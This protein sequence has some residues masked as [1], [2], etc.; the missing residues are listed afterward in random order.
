MRERRSLYWRLNWYRQSEL[1]GALL[2]GRMV[3][4]ATDP[5]LV[6]RLTSHCA[7]EARHAWLWMRTLETLGLPS[8]RIRR[9]YQSFYLDEISKPRTLTEVLALTH[10]FEHRVH[11]HFTDELGRRG[12]PDLARRTFRAMLRDEQQHLDWIAGWLSAQPAAAAVLDR[13]RSADE[14]VV[15][16]LTPYRERLWDIEGLGEERI[17]G[18]DGIHRDA[19]QELHT[20]QSQH[21]A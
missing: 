14:R 9:S 21:P 8:V 5:Y 16:R 3:R 13:Y 20:A 19:T 2:L 1:E 17:E 11:R 7:D 15:Q 6:G 12:L 4:H 18:S 10:I